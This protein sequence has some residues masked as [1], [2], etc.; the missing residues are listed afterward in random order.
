MTNI[1]QIICQS[2]NPFDKELTTGNFWYEQPNNGL[3]VNSIH[4]GIIDKVQNILTNINKTKTSKTIIIAGDSG[5][6]KSY[7]LGRIKRNLN[8]KAFFVY[9]NPWP[10]SSFIWRHIL[11][12]TVDS[13]VCQPEGQKESQL[14]L[15]IKS[16]SAFRERGFV[17]WV[18]GERGLFMSNLRL[19]YP[20]GIYNAREFFGVLYDLTNPELYPLACDWLRGDDL[21]E[22][23]LQKLRVKRSIDSEQV[24]K[25]ILG[26]FGKI[27]VHTQPIVLCFDQLDNIPNLDNGFLD[28]QALF[29]VNSTIHNEYYK[30]ILIIISTITDTWNR[31][32]QQIQPAD[33]ARVNNLVS[34]KSINLEQAE[35]LWAMRLHSLHS[36]AHTKPESNIYPLTREQLKTAFPGGKTLPRNA[37]ILGLKL[38]NE[39]QKKIS[40]NED[41]VVKQ[42]KAQKD[43]ANYVKD[44]FDKPNILKSFKAVWNKEYLKNQEQITTYNQIAEPELIKILREVLAAWNISAISPRLLSGKYNINSFSYRTSDNQKIGVVWTENINMTSFC[45]VMKACQQVITRK[46]CHNLYLIR[47]AS[48]GNTKLKGNQIYRHI[49]NNSS[50]HHL[51]PSLNDIHYLTTYHQLVNSAKGNELLVLDK[52]ISLEQLESLIRESGLISPCL[53][54]QNLKIIPVAQ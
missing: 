51:K 34:L 44:S 30:K 24:A 52:V 13:L 15:W 50:H 36:Q 35:A 32:K 39:Y 8:Q 41:V 1:N 6:G 23:D 40:K 31:N 29:N 22:E 48:V 28:L 46:H 7:L 43:A 25:N 47:A 42:K 33:L 38:F 18:L 26:N 37:L 49:F 11:R 16:L 19:T 17:K 5:S 54:L 21:E 9:I 2:D 12:Q 3:M 27:A 45:S 4:Q 53:L 20:V 14:L 10:D